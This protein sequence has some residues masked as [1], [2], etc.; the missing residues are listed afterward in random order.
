MKR[1][2]CV[3]LALVIL[4]TFYPFTASAVDSLP[5][6]NALPLI[7]VRGMDSDA[8]TVH[9]PDGSVGPPIKPISFGGV[10]KTL[11]EAGVRGILG[12]DA[13]SALSVIAAYAR[14]RLEHL[15]CDEKGQPLCEAAIP[16]YPLSV[17]HYEQLLEDTGYSENN[18]VRASVARFGAERT[19]YF[20]YDWRVNPLENADAIA[21]LIDQ[22]L[23][24]TGCD[25]VN[26]VCASLGGVQTVAYI[27]KYGYDKLNKCVFVSSTFHGSYLVT[28]LIN[29][30]IGVDG[31]TLYEYLRYETRDNAVVSF[32]V[33]AAR[34]TGLLHVVAGLVNRLI[35]PLI[36]PIHEQ[37]LVDSVARIPI[38]WALMLPEGYESALER[39]FAGREQEHAEFINMTAQLQRMMRGRDALLRQAAA[40]GVQFA[41]IA[42]YNTPGAPVFARGN[43]HGDGTLET[44][45]MAGGAKVAKFGKTLPADYVSARPDC[46]SP[47]F[48]IDTS[49][50]LFPDNTWLIKG[51]P[52]VGCR[53]GSEY[54]EFLFWILDYPEAADVYA[55]ARYPRFMQSNNQQDL[56]AQVE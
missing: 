16:T 42:G 8:L 40:G 56:F 7:V 44:A 18:I 52:H 45:L 3:L 17:S 33:R 9:Y 28:D 36:D 23:L 47:D 34:Y 39:C 31:D 41:V 22:A 29:G 38:L 26:L 4:V 6:D 32:L 5:A 25:K 2:L 27:T 11:L 15:A 14:D 1:A 51:A 19:Y 54:S 43:E 55:D 21:A 49:S 35:S 10:M 50:C 20:A 53:F 13:G 30:D 37:V 48:V 46:I 24:D 12:G